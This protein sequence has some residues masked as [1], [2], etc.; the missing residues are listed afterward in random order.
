MKMPSSPKNIQ[1]NEA[2]KIQTIDDNTQ[3]IEATKDKFSE[4]K[5]SYTTIP[6]KHI[7]PGLSLDKKSEMAIVTEI[8]VLGNNPE[9]VAPKYGLSNTK[10][11]REILQRYVEMD[12]ARDN[13]A[14]MQKGLGISFLGIAARCAEKLRIMLSDESHK[15]RASEVAIIAGIA[16][17]RGREL[18]SEPGTDG[19]TNWGEV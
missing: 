7:N 16:S 17:Q 14:N 15:W 19:P 9:D 12:G 8:E 13:I 6:D 18:L 4:E 3:A 1:A 10:T 5:H 11:V 2:E